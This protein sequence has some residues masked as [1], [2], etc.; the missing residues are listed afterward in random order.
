MLLGLLVAT[1][2]AA[3]PSDLLLRGL[4]LTRDTDRNVAILVSGGRTRVVAAGENAFGGKVVSV[5]LQGVVVDF[6]GQLS[7]LRLAAAPVPTTPAPTAVAATGRPTEDPD[8]PARK[9]VRADVERRLGV[10]MNRILTDTALTPV[11][12]DGRMVGVAISRIAQGSLLTE[13]GLRVGDVITEINGTSI[14]GPATLMSLYP[15]LQSEKV[16]NATVLRGGRPVS[17][18]LTLQ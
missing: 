7:T 9:M 1:T 3:P 6:D 14:D 15:R 2:L 16:I 5:S 8:T 13:A 18:Q 17:L 12:E 4:V 11:T 10:E